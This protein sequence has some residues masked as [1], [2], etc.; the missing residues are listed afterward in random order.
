MIRGRTLLLIGH[1]T[2]AVRRAKALG[3][4]VILLQHK[5][6]L[7]AEQARHADA[8][9]MVDYRDW[10]LVSRLAG[11]IHEF[12]GFQAALSMTD[13]GLEIAGRINDQ[14]GLP[15]TGFE[16]SH[17]LH[18]KLAMRR[19]LAD[20]GIAGISAELVAGRDSL[21]LFGAAHGYPFI[22]KPADLSGGFG[23]MLVSD[24]AGVGDAWQRIQ[25]LRETG[26][27]HGPGALFNVGRFIMEEYADGPE[28]SVETFSFS[29]RHVVVAV[30]EKLVGDGHFA[31]L[32]H[33]IPARVEP[34]VEHD[35]VTSV[36]EFLDVIGLADGPAHT[37]VRVG[38]R[39]PVVIESH[40]RAGGDRIRDL[41]RAV[42]G[43]DLMTYAVGWPF[44]LVSELDSRPRPAAGACVRFFY[45]DRGRVTGVGGFDEVRAR[46]DVIAAESF[47]ALGDEVRPLRDN[48]DRLG[49]VA[50]V[51]ADADA[52]VKVCEELASSSLRIDVAPAGMSGAETAPGTGKG[53]A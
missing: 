1:P 24:A 2:D 5:S 37:E 33:V 25:S 26:L 9:F 39:G 17:L 50:V 13:P 7:E 27:T 28:Y 8:M 14:Y 46:D 40:N 12:W 35:I 53:D 21:P 30:T 19:R 38:T 4:N 48:F 42:Y 29:G 3:L 20:R 31:E 49:L 52:A 47:V 6:K 44:G 32:G 34:A 16:V 11:L 10:D 41:V 43:I 36:T 15:G 45:A 22:V 51:G 23:V 18:D